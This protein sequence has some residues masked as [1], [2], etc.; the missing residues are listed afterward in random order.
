MTSQVLQ[1]K[2]VNK[3]YR[4]RHT[5]SSVHRPFPATFS[6]L[7]SVFSSSSP[8][9]FKTNKCEEFFIEDTALLTISRSRVYCSY[10]YT[11]A[12]AENTYHRSLFYWS[13]DFLFWI[14]K[15]ITTYFLLWS[16]P[17]HSQNV[18][19]LFSNPSPYDESTLVTPLVHLLYIID[20]IKAIN[21][22]VLLLS[23]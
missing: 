23:L 11:K 16:N 6:Y 5:F 1:L 9:T 2:S 3:R 19:Q 14:I 17:N 15:H 22:F 12:H 10:H 4:G 21:V 20:R 8:Y 13:Q 7:F 18:D